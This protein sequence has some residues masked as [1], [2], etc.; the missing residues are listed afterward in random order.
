MGNWMFVYSEIWAAASRGQSQQELLSVLG[1]DRSINKLSLDY[2]IGELSWD[3][4][5]SQ[6]GG[7]HLSSQIWQRNDWVSTQRDQSEWVKV[8]FFVLFVSLFW[9]QLA[10]WYFSFL[11]QQVV[12][13]VITVWNI[14]KP[15]RGGDWGSVY[16]Q[17]RF[18]WSSLVTMLV[19]NYL[20]KRRSTSKIGTITT[21]LQPGNT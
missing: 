6:R 2:F 4:P 20:N 11:A 15:T 13:W 18:Q 3:M 16:L 17:Q 10:A 7:R 19:K 8:F 1:L 9:L 12:V 21:L 5:R 14:F